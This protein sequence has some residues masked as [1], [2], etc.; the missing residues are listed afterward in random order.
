MNLNEMSLNDHGLA[1]RAPECGQLISGYT[2]EEN[3]ALY[4][5]NH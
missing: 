2:T 4:Y 3:D 5:T 1:P